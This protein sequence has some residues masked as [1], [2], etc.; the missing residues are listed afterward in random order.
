[1]IRFLGAEKK[2]IQIYNT[3]VLKRDW[4]FGKKFESTIIQGK[5]LGN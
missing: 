1:M 5:Y 4:I 3:K 2:K